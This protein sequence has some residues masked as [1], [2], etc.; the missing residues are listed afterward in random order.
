MQF[1]EPMKVV[2]GGKI[3]F[4]HITFIV[5]LWFPCSDWLNVL[6]D[7]I[8]WVQTPNSKKNQKIIQN[9][10]CNSSFAHKIFHVA[11][12]N[13]P[14]DSFLSFQFHF[15]VGFFFTSVIV[16][17][18]I[19]WCPFITGLIFCHFI[20]WI[21]NLMI[22]TKPISHGKNHRIIFL[23]HIHAF[24]EIRLF[25]FFSFEFIMH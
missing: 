9:G 14:S 4:F 13:M 11:W 15:Y 6:H 24:W 7:K 8:Q 19:A 12:F 1:G 17:A 23:L 3:A 2:R 21:C 18:Y 25:I 10:I 16:M 5:I 22:Q 20:L